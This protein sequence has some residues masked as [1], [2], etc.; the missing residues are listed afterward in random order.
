MSQ[1]MEGAH[2]I[3]APRRHGH[4]RDE[5]EDLHAASHSLG[6]GRLRPD[7]ART[8]ASRTS[9]ARPRAPTRAQHEV[10]AEPRRAPTGPSCRSTSRSL[11][12]RVPRASSCGILARRAAPSHLDADPLAEEVAQRRRQAHDHLGAG[13]AHDAAAPTVSSS[14]RS[15]SSRSSGIALRQPADAR[16]VELGREVR[17][18]DAVRHR[19]HRLEP[20]RPRRTARPRRRDARRAA[21]LA[22]AATS[23]P[24]VSGR[25]PHVG[26]QEDRRVAARGARAGGSTRSPCRRARCRERAPPTGPASGAPRRRSPL[27]SASTSRGLDAALRARTPGHRPARARGGDRRSGRPGTSTARRD[28]AG[29][30]LQLV[31]AIVQRAPERRL[32]GTTRDGERHG[33]RRHVGR[34]RHARTTRQYVAAV[35]RRPSS[36]ASAAFGAELAPRPRPRKTRAA[37]R[38]RAGDRSATRPSRPPPRGRSRTA[39]RAHVGAV[40]GTRARHVQRAGARAGAR[41][42]RGPCPRRRGSSPDRTR[43]GARTAR[44]RTAMNVPYTQSTRWGRRRQR[45]ASRPGVVSS[46]RCPTGPNRAAPGCQPPSS[47]TNPP[48]AMPMPALVERG[49]AAPGSRPGAH[50]HPGSGRRRRRPPRATHPDSRPRRTRGC[51]P[52]STTVTHGRPRRPPSRCRRCDALSTTITAQPRRVVGKALDARAGACRRRSS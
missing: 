43:R 40:D 12:C 47:F 14:Q 20:R 31:H 13:R 38:A 34:S 33:G 25:E 26:V 39:A 48:P 17:E 3:A 46:S 1:V 5:D 30:A 36:P 6:R 27:A 11:G 22:S 24:S 28:V 52:P 50:A 37:G 23:R 2:L 8:P 29:P 32:V 18:V 7:V 45:A 4:P 16:G 15:G 9:D 49:R 21:R 41:D 42:G 44:A 10:H 19:H 51:D 35:R